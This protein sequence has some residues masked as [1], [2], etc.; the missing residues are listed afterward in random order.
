MIQI[1][2]IYAHS[3]ERHSAPTAEW[4][5][6]HLASQTIVSIS[7]KMSEIGSTTASSPRGIVIST[8]NKSTPL[9]PAFPLTLM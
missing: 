7:Q 9:D 8:G 6:K 3:S 2:A 1:Q 5:S 4:P